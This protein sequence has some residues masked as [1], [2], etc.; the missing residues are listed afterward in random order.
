MRV[1]SSALLLLAAAV[2]PLAGVAFAGLALDVRIPTLTRDPAAIAE[3][4]PLVGVL[5]TLGVLVL[6]GSTAIWFLAAG[7]LRVRDEHADSLFAVVTGLA[8]S[9][10]TLDDAFEVHE[11]LAPTYLGISENLAVGALATAGA[12]YVGAL[13][14]RILSAEAWPLGLA[15]A[16][17]GGSVV[18]DAVLAP[19]FWPD[20]NWVY[21]VEDGLKWIG[22][23]CV[24]T[25]SVRWCGSR[26]ASPSAPGSRARGDP[27]ANSAPPA[28]PDE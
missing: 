27:S 7:I 8:L 6:A 25:G 2:A 15:V 14:R 9:Y 22:I 3:I 20:G 17:F 24:A 10:L 5:S 12:L 1:S 26:L 13:H 4:H 18:L 16:L 21:L 19:R 11:V 28:A 23:V